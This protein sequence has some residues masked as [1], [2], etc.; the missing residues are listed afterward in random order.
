MS[1]K[2]VNLEK[3]TDKPSEKTPVA[4]RAG[5][6]QQPNPAETKETVPTIAKILEE[7]PADMFAKSAP[8]NSRPERVK[9]CKAHIDA[10]AG[11]IRPGQTDEVAVA[12]ATLGLSKMIELLETLNASD[13]SEVLDYLMKVISETNEAGTKAFDKGYVFVGLDS[14]T[15][16]SARQHFVRMMNLFTTYAKLHDKSKLGTK[17]SVG[18]SLEYVKDENGRKAIA[19]YFA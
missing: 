8:A 4:V 9:I 16:L 14:L 11:T 10:F 1:D 3:P 15:S 6:E 12:T 13:V 2:T 5:T 7:A 17:C 19:A 18:Y